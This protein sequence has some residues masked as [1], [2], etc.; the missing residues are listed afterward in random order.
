MAFVSIFYQIPDKHET[1]KLFFL[2]D[3]LGPLEPKRQHKSLQNPTSLL[4]TV[5]GPRIY[6]AIVKAEFSSLFFFF[7]SF[8]AHCFS[9]TSGI[10]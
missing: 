4:A 10:S 3:I 5:F 6:P 1:V 7:L 8:S 9:P 2:A